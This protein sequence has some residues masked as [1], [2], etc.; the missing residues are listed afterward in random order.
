MFKSSLRIYPGPTDPP[1]DVANLFIHNLPF[2]L[3]SLLPSLWRQL[4]STA[5]SI[6]ISTSLPSPVGWSRKAWF[7]SANL[8]PTL[9]W[10]TDRQTDRQADKQAYDAGKGLLAPASPTFHE[11][12]SRRSPFSTVAAEGASSSACMPSRCTFLLPPGPA[13]PPFARRTLP[14]RSLKT[15]TVDP[16]AT[17]NRALIL[18]PASR[19]IPSHFTP[20]FPRIITL[21]CSHTPVLPYPHTPSPPHSP[22]ATL[23]PS[24]P[25]ASSSL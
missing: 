13:A 5:H 15:L 11:P 3:C 22:R 21:A 7:Y 19:P 23:P 14:S 20:L 10:Q 6:E 2:N 12:P 9:T 24:Y 16:A 17:P 4:G 18:R 1:D 8:L 25:P